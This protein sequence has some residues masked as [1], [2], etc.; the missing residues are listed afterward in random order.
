[1]KVAKVTLKDGFAWYTNQEEG[2]HESVRRV[3]RKR[4]V[5]LEVV[6]VIEMTEAEYYAIP[7]TNELHE[8]LRAEPSSNDDR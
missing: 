2:F 4:G 8:L 5:G 7:A 1:M 3:Q 6:E